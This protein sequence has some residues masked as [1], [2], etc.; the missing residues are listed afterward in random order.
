MSPRRI[1]LTVAALACALSL[2]A[3]GSA[4]KHWKLLKKGTDGVRAAGGDEGGRRRAPWI[5][6]ASDRKELDAL[7]GEHVPGKPGAVDFA[8]ES[9]IFLLLGVQETGGYAI[10]PVSVEPPA[11]G[12]VRGHARQI[13][14]MGD[15]MVTEA[16][17][18]PYAVIAVRARGIR[19]VEWVNDGRLLATRIVE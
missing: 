12:V 7:W 17:T 16:L 15:E 1:A 19:K 18:A 14:P 5:E 2:A 4:P 8:A 11:E 9:V 3:A 13:Q 6:I 10:E